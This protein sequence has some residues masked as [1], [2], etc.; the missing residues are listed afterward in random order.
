MQLDQRLSS[1]SI[2]QQR[3]YREAKEMVLGG[4]DRYIL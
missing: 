1:D 4:D 2:L 3:L